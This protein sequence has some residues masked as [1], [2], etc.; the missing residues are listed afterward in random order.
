MRAVPAR[1][2]P[3]PAY[4]E[5]T[6]SCG[7]RTQPQ[8]FDQKLQIRPKQ[9]WAE[10]PPLKDLRPIPCEGRFLGLRASGG[11]RTRFLSLARNSCFSGVEPGRA[12]TDTTRGVGMFFVQCRIMSHQRFISFWTRGRTSHPCMH[13]TAAAA[14]TA[15]VVSQVTEQKKN[16]V[17]RYFEYCCLILLYNK[18]VM[19]ASLHLPTPSGPSTPPPPPSAATSSSSPPAPPPTP[20]SSPQSSSSPSSARPEVTLRMAGRQAGQTTSKFIREGVGGWACG[21]LFKLFSFVH[22]GL[23]KGCT[24]T[25]KVLLASSHFLSIPLTAYFG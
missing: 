4:S 19:F 23:G 22:S 14:A 10:R 1:P 2:G 5:E 15:A 8:I 16:C 21:S 6:P 24:R 20:S 12:G 7:Q 25:S 3:G 17:I 11:N 9:N 13:L 18:S